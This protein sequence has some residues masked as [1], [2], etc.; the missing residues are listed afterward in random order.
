MSSGDPASMY[1]ATATE[2]MSIS[3]AWKAASAI[4]PRTAN[5]GIPNRARTMSKIRS[6]A[7]AYVSTSTSAV[8]GRVSR[9]RNRLTSER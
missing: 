6:T 1:M 8:A 4:E 7:I 5:S 9:A 2:E 3:A